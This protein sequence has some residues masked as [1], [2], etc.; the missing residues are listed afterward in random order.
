MP[1]IRLKVDHVESLPAINGQ[2]TDYADTK[3]PGLFLRVSPSGV[4]SWSVLYSRGRGRTGR[5]TVRETLGSTKEL[6][7]E[8]ARVRAED[9]IAS[10]Q[11]TT[12]R[13][14]LAQLLR[15]FL[16]DISR[17]VA[18]T[19]LYD[20]DRS[21]KQD[22]IP[23]LGDRP[24]REIERADVRGLLKDIARRA[25]SLSN[26]VHTILRRAFNWAIEEEILSASPMAKLRKLHTDKPRERVLSADE[27]RRLIGA[28]ARLR[29]DWTQADSTLLLLL[30]GVRKAAVT[31]M[32]RSELHG[33]D[34]REPLWIVPPERSK[35]QRNSTSA[36]RPHHVPLSPWAVEVIQR[37]IA[38][39]DALGLAK[40]EHLFPSTSA[41]AI[42]DRPPGWATDWVRMMR[43]EM[44]PVVLD[45]TGSV[46]GPGPMDQHWCVHSLRHTAATHMV[47]HL[48][49]EVVVADLILGHVLPGTPITRRYIRAELL[50]ERRSALERWATYLE[51]LAE[52]ATGA[53]V[54]PFAAAGVA[55]GVQHAPVA[56][57]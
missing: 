12:T 52:P 36:T 42:E 34:G 44:R 8:E 3:C 50:A 26:H 19:T 18:K 28:L 27:L 15:R 17:D 11:A 33:L 21:V 23:A 20:W 9:V 25:P 30:T 16:A 41:K 57:D 29:G 46:V 53:K 43:E 39:L 24:A 56:G 54:L 38:T 55:P 31:G 14:T 13:L 40:F 10:G 48:R 49:V 32:R 35:R 2:R 5:R 4:R 51:R 6:T 47:E 7:L 45:A 1:R 22:I 37:R